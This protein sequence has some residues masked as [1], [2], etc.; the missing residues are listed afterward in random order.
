MNASAGIAMKIMAALSSTLM[1]ACVKGL[2]GAIPVGEVI[3][4][5]SVLA[6]VPLMIWLKTQGSIVEGI[7]TRN[8]RGHFLRGLA[9]TGGLYFSY[10]SLLYI[11]LTDATAI[12]Y[13][14]PLFTVLLAALLLREKVRHHRWVAVVAGFSG[15][16]V[17]FSGHLSLKASFSL[18]ASAGIL[19]A[20]MAAFCTAC[21]LV[22]IRFLHGKEKP[23][24]IAFW[25]A[26]TTATTS[27]ITLAG[28]W[29]VPQ[30]TQLLLLVG[31]GLLGGIT[32]ILMTLSLRYAEASLLAPFDYTTLLWSVAVGYLFLGNLPESTTVI[33]A[34]LVVLGGLY[35]LLYER[36]RFRRNRAVSASS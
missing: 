36:Y 16:I 12:N 6:L 26:V 13:A 19:L 23:G 28:G 2:D 30:G 34:I 31:C 27:L 3:F 8:V 9:G 10:L 35:S 1:L 14:A 5:R 4:F 22:Q 17:M 7:R 32:Q 25:F 21:A 24:A 11:S 29:I 18:A 20:L 33:G 15:I